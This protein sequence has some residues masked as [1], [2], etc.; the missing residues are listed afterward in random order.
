MAKL[1]DE[2]KAANKVV[3]K[4]HGKAFYKRRKDFDA[5]KGLAIDNFNSKDPLKAQRDAADA[6]WTAGL[7]A[8]GVDRRGLRSQIVDLQEQIEGLDAKHNTEALNDARKATSNAY[9]NGLRAVE[10][11]INAEF[12]DV[13]GI[14]SAF[15]WKP[16]L[17][18]PPASSPS[19]LV[20]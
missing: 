11:G 13:A 17:T 5:A 2:Q 19:G 16:K 8:V 4:A 18:A 14:F 1:T 7:E 12:S 15:A 6:A 3:H 9:F 20:P 10:Q